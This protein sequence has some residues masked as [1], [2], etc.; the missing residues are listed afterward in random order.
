MRAASSN[1]QTDRLRSSCLTE[2]RHVR[3]SLRFRGK[4]ICVVSQLKTTEVNSMADRRSVAIAPANEAPRRRLLRAACHLATA[5]IAVFALTAQAAPPPAAKFT[6]GPPVAVD[7]APWIKTRFPDEHV[8]FTKGPGG[9]RL[10]SSAG[11]GDTLVYSS[12]DLL[13]FLPATAGPVFGPPRT[14]KSSFDENYA[15]AGAV[16]IDPA[17]PREFYMLYEADSF[18]Y[19]TSPRVCKGSD[20]YWASIG[21]AHADDPLNTG[22]PKRWTGFANEQNEAGRTAALVSPD[23]KPPA[24]PALGYYGDGIPSGFVDP[25]DPLHRYLYA[26]FEYHPNPQRSDAESRVEVARDAFTDLR[27]PKLAPDF[28]KFDIAPGPQH[29]FSVQFDDR[30]SPIV[31]SAAGGACTSQER[32]SVSY[33]TALQKYL[34]VLVCNRIPGGATRDWY[35]TTTDNIDA[36][37]WAVPLPLAQYSSDLPW[38]PSLVSPDQPDSNTTGGSGVIFFQWGTYAPYTRTFSIA[39]PA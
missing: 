27:S 26:Y 3:F 19:G 34:M 18:C 35:Y 11:S 10:W 7:Y 16:V 28:K 9:F 23:K 22:N 25:R 12:A 21:I 29:G 6:L 33:N 15:G 14:A 5:G 38:Y 36:Q 32:P 31:P 2:K 30:G 20:Y 4:A 24:P 13:H 8:S 39:P 37:A 17:N 1:A